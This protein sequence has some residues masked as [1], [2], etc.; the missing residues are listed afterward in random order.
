MKLL[1]HIYTLP[2]L[3]SL[4][5]VALLSGCSQ[6]ELPEDTTPTGDTRSF[7][8]T[9]SDSGYQSFKG[10]STRST[11]SSI[12]ARSTESNVSTRATESS[13]S[14]TFTAGDE[15]GVYAV[16]N[17]Q[18][19]SNIDNLRLTAT[20]D[21]KGGI[22]WK[23]V[24]GTAPERY[25]GDATYY[26]YYPYQNIFSG[27]YEPDATAPTP[28][29][30]FNI[31]I[32]N[33]N[34]AKNQSAYDSYTKQD[35]MVSQGTVLPATG[36]GLPRLS[37]SM[38]HCMALAVIE[39][40][41]TSYDTLLYGDIDLRTYI[42]DGVPDTKFSGF[43]P[44]R[45]S[46]GTYR[47]L[48]K[49]SQT[50]LK[51]TG[52]YAKNSTD[53]AEWTFSAN[54]ANGNYQTY[55]VDGGKNSVIDLETHSLQI[56]DFFMKDGS[57]VSKDK[58]LT[59]QQKAACIG[60]VFSTYKSDDSF[61]YSTTGIG[62]NDC[63]GYVMALT[64]VNEG[65]GDQLKWEYRAGDG[66]YDQFVGTSTDVSDWNGYRNTQAIKTYATTNSGWAM[67]DFPAANAC[68]LY[69]TAN[70]LYDWQKKYTAP[71][72]SSGWFLPSAGQLMYLYDHD[73]F[74]ALSASIQALNSNSNN[75]HVKWLDTNLAYWSSSEDDPT[76][77]DHANYVILDNLGLVS[78]GPEIKY[79][80]FSVRAILAF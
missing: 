66:K 57:L 23:V 12:S 59:E 13:I 80:E 48:V 24:F 63:H 73:N 14:T 40:P 29:G 33:W 58:T 18:I 51:L 19:L 26:A 75:S 69:G 47:L 32:K 36:G 41:R 3:M 31:L 76:Y 10:T 78:A 30:F 28:A 45:M 68:L 54:I 11:G 67:T 64:D 39:L 42:I 38:K 20:D 46:D 8:I 27:D 9:V 22:E 53:I 60:I 17:G 37:F 70:S 79:S 2:L 15:I 34:P 55:A 74:S 44:Y 71:A 43:T 56:G 5:S 16:R 1:K 4:F 65:S 35:L 21:G 49:P 52:S 62:R 61:D 7:T 72:R 50:N 77:S 6:K 25:P